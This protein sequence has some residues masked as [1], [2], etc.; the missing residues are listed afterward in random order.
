LNKDKARVGF[1][2]LLGKL[3]E[4]EHTLKYIK[5]GKTIFDKEMMKTTY[6]NPFLKN[7]K[8][9]RKLMKF[10][11]ASKPLNDGSPFINFVDDQKQ[12]LIS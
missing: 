12:P 3:D 8:E 5:N 4:T 7:P 11:E 10:I 9:K 6:T 1:E 2:E